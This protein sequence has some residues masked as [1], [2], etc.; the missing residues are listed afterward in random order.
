[1][2]K[3]QVDCRS[4]DVCVT[5]SLFEYMNRLGHTEYRDGVIEVDIS[6]ES[7]RKES[8]TEF[9]TTIGNVARPLRRAT[10]THKKIRF[11]F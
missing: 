5:S 6:N 10:C 7:V 9:V 1:M 8:M 2:S 4:L 3:V 11:H